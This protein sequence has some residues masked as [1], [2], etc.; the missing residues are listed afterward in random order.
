MNISLHHSLHDDC[1]NEIIGSLVLAE[2]PM[3]AWRFSLGR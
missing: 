1:Q 3:G 2:I